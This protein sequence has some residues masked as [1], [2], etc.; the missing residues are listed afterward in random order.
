MNTNSRSRWT[1]CCHALALLLGVHRSPTPNLRSGR[2]KRRLCHPAGGGAA[3]R[4]APARVGVARQTGLACGLPGDSC[5]VW[6][7]ECSYR[8]NLSLKA[9]AAGTCKLLAGAKGLSLNW[10][11]APKKGP[12]K[13]H[14]ESSLTQPGKALQRAVLLALETYLTHPTGAATWL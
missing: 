13:R 1:P 6:L 3:G 11:M 9:L 8:R 5:R 14:L 12:V 7:T 2:P 4:S 10:E